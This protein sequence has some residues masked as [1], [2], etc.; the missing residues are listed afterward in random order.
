MVES[1]IKVIIIWYLIVFIGL[2]LVNI[3]L[4]IISGKFIKLIVFVELIVGIKVVWILLWINIVE[5][6]FGVVLRFSFFWICCCLL[7]IC[8]FKLL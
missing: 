3:S 2:I 8:C 7:M 1:S 5:V 4:D 6:C